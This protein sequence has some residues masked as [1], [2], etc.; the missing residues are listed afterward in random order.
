MKALTA[1]NVIAAN[2]TIRKVHIE[3]GAPNFFTSIPAY[4]L[5]FSR[6]NPLASGAA[7][8]LGI[9]PVRRR[10]DDL[11]DPWQRLL[12]HP[13][14][15]SVDANVAIADVRT[16]MKARDID[17]IA[18][19]LG[20]EAIGVITRDSMLTALLD[21]EQ[22]LLQE[23]QRLVTATH[24]DKA[25]LIVDVTERVQV[26]A[27]M[28][29][30]ATRLKLAI[31]A[32]EMSIWEW[33][34]G[35]DEWLV[36]ERMRDFYFGANNTSNPAGDDD[37]AGADWL[38]RIHPDDLQPWLDRLKNAVRSKTPHDD[39]L[40]SYDTLG[41]LRHVKIHAIAEYDKDGVPTRMV[42]THIDFTDERLAQLELF[43]HR[44]ELQSLVEKQTMELI[45]ARDTALHANKLQAEFLANMSHELRTPLHS[46]IGFAQL[47]IEDQAFIDATQQTR[48][49]RK[50]LA[51]A[52]RLL[53]LVNDLLDLAKLE[54]G[55]FRFDMHKTDLPQLLQQVLTD[56]EPLFTAKKMQVQRLI[57]DGITGI[58]LWCDREKIGQ[59]LRNLLSNAIKFSP[60]GSTIT[61]ELCLRAERKAW[62][63]RISD[64]GM[65]I[66]SAEL[67][68]IFDKFIQSSATNSGSGGTGL[69]LPISR[70]IVQAHGGKIW[71][72]NNPMR[73]ASFHLIVPCAPIVS[74]TAN[75]Q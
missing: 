43:A 55:S 54:A 44:T 66:P 63:M 38:E 48:H 42:G 27:T 7:C 71:A 70:E 21:Q 14:P 62:E 6:A 10:T 34:L 11:S 15:D 75:G 72:S 61:I 25:R 13:Q 3:D 51:N 16:Q 28:R 45:V 58:D 9:V 53:R 74:E 19:F 30:L 36:D 31:A 22:R 24:D 23:G 56:A 46:I 33:R 37:V 59:V 20:D 73:G 32:S 4:Y 68:A 49:L 29:E 39:L 65:G 18:V 50:V 5:V 69:G 1:I 67:E 41:N 47:C 60:A 12:Q 52:E 40:R 64:Q 26:D 17:V 8:F 57:D 2:A 35:T